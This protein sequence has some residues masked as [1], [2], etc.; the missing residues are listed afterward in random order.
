MYPVVEPNSPLKAA[1]T[2]GFKSSLCLLGLVIVFQSGF[3]IRKLNAPWV[4]E[5]DFNGAVWSQAAHTLLRSNWLENA[6]LPAPFYF[7]PMP[8]PNEE[9]YVHHP[10]L[11]AWL[12][13]ASF[14]I[15]GE[16]EW[17]ARLVPILAS[18]AGTILVW[19][20]V[21]RSAGESAAVL[22]A[23]IFATMPMELCMGQMVNFEPLALMFALVGF[24]GWSLFESTEKPAWRWL[25]IAGS[26][27]AMLV[28]WTGYMVVIMGCILLLVFQRKKYGRLALGLIGMAIVL[29]LL[30]LVQISF[31]R[32]DAIDD[33]MDSFRWRMGQSSGNENFTLVQWALKA[34]QSMLSFIPVSR[35]LI[36]LA[37]LL[38][39][40]AR[41][42]AC[43]G[44]KKL[45]WIS[46]CFFLMNLAYVT[47][48]R[49][50]SYIHD[51]ASFY[52]MVPVALMGG[53]GLRAL[54][55]ACTKIPVRIPETAWISL[56]LVILGF[57]GWRESR[58]LLTP[59]YILTASDAEPQN[60]IPSLGRFIQKEFSPDSDVICNFDLY[61]APQ[62]R[63]Y[64]KR[65][66]LNG[67]MDDDDWQTYTRPSIRREES[68]GWEP[69]VPPK[70]FRH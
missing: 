34:G 67:L 55:A 14:Q 30:F 58:D 46:L 22:S 50:A 57:L 11:L 65:D 1:Q 27:G 17:A 35:W 31:V 4:D 10:T 26:V 64:A 68:S 43:P 66:I 52:F 32:A 56:A 37:G 6:G 36:A 69:P 16:H 48:F 23:A 44:L 21:R 7:G 3:F 59:E 19:L 33:A 41:R 51:Y 15:F 18:L 47:I 24:L 8:V 42:S 61:Y 38:V 28:G 12:V 53:P 9:Y 40:W 54:F 25:M 20:I 13:A 49:N 63:Y 5:I 2:F 62:L 60:L 39:M 29:S 70:S 45:G